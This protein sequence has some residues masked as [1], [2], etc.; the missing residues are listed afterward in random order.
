MHL[1]LHFGTDGQILG[2][3]GVGRAGIDKRIDI[4]ATAARGGLRADDLVDLDLCYAPPF[5]SAML[6]MIADNVLSGRLR[7]HDPAR[8]IDPVGSL[9][10]DVRNRDEWDEAH[11]DG[12]VLIPQPDVARS[13]ELIRDLAAGRP[14]VVHCASGFRSYLAH[15]T[16]VG[17]GIPNT[18]VSGGFRTLSVL[19]P[20]LVASRHVRSRGGQA[21][22]GQSGR[23][24]WS[25][26]LPGQ[27]DDERNHGQQDERRQK[28]QTQR[29]DDPHA[30]PGGSQLNPPGMPPPRILRGA[31]QRAGRRDARRV[32]DHRRSP[33]DLPIGPD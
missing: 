6:G 24:G 10:I 28:G 2:A 26:Q 25:P 15:R 32:G 1:V 19:A 31:A 20:G 12:A 23:P 9:V 5:G 13:V 7:Q 11:I 4:I 17:A 30:E 29:Q 16:L 33:G 14:I 3:Q 8:G 27:G 21:A 18:N 22:R